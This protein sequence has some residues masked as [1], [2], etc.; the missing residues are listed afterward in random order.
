MEEDPQELFGGR[1]RSRMAFSTLIMEAEFGRP[2]I[3]WKRIDRGFLVEGRFRRIF[4]K[5]SA[6]N[7]FGVL[8]PTPFAL[9]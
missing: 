1:E 3:L 5:S 2:V 8:L 7:G 6:I 9:G 4:S